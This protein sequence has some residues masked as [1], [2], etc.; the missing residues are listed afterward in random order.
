VVFRNR[1][2]NSS[3]EAKAPEAPLITTEATG[4]V[5]LSLQN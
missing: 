5:M 4:S 2:N 1:S 3:I